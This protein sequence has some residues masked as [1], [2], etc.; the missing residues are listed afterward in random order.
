MFGE[1]SA[2]LQR[3]SSLK[4]S[5]TRQAARP[6]L[7]GLE[8]R[9]LFSTAYAL[10]GNSGTVLAK[11]DTS[12]PDT[13]V[14]TKTVDG[15]P[16]GMTLRGIDFRPA[17][18]QLFALG[19]RP[20]SGD[21]EGQVFTLDFKNTGDATAV[22]PV[23]STGL[24]ASLPTAPVAYGFD[25]NPASDRIRIFNDDDQNI[26]V[27]PNT[28]ALVDDDTD[29]DNPNNDEEVTGGAYDR[30]VS[31]VPSPLFGDAPPV[32]TLFGIDFQNDSL[33]RIG[34]ID[35][36]APEGSPNLGVVTEIGPLGFSTGSASNGFDIGQDGTAF[37]LLND[38]D[39]GLTSLY[40]I[41]LTTGG[42][43]EV[44]TLNNGAEIVSG[45]AIAPDNR[46]PTAKADTYTV[47]AGGSI[48]IAAPGVLAN[49]TDPEGNPLTAKIITTPANSQS[50]SFNNSGAFTYTPAPGFAGTDSFT[51]VANDG[52]S[53]SGP[54]TTVTINVLPT[55]TID[56]PA[57]AEGSNGQ[58]DLAFTLTLSAASASEVVVSYKTSNGSAGE[59]D[60]VVIPSG[61]VTFA[62]GETTKDVTIQVK[63]DTKI[64]NDETFTLKLTS[65][66][67]ASI[68]DSSGTGTILND[69]MAA[70]TPKVFIGD[71]QIVEG[72]SGTKNLVF[73]VTLDVASTKTIT[74]KYATQNFTAGEGDY[75]VKS[76]NLTFAAGETVK[77]FSIVIKGDTKGEFNE[78]FRVNLSSLVNVNAGDVQAL[79]TILSDDPF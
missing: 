16:A 6:V 55:V 2:R 36:G 1:F 4:R 32:T 66:T 13:I 70:V 5:S 59:G 65:A 79:G 46:P 60:Y 8:Q 38:D 41:D 3:G 74:L 57:V 71:A 67:G 63:G 29:L 23:F 49:D 44:D 58:Q 31:F 25:F 54:A 42:A 68:A 33:V 51:Y 14:S 17:T 72:N 78:Q 64:E 62:A 61:K 7:E 77:Q 10:F 21:D 26:R 30:N 69:D 9:R 34:G 37:A 22:G 50:F 19:I 52:T 35:G 45:F 39:T 73:T 28:G 47:A 18:G 27:N 43:T 75:G 15:L 56:D 11:F 76:G 48:S 53:D 24:A 20:T 40:S 12:D